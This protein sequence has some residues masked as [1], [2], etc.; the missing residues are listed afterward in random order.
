MKWKRNGPGLTMSLCAVLCAVTCGCNKP[1][2][3]SA[4]AGFL[5]PQVTVQRTAQSNAVWPGP[6]LLQI[7]ANY[8]Y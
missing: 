6:Y 4:P 3:D 5:Q 2:G 8:L 7:M 1:A